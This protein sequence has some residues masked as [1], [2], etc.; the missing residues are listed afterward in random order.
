MSKACSMPMCPAVNAPATGGMRSKS[1]RRLAYVV[2]LPM[3]RW[4]G[5]ELA[6]IRVELESELGE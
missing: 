5:Q 1:R 3:W 6:N 4:G 2:N